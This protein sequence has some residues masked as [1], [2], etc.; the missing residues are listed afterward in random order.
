MFGKMLAPCIAL[1][2]CSV[3]PGMTGS[4]VVPVAV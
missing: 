1:A 2:C 3:R 4:V